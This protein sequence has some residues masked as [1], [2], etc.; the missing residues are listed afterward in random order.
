MGGFYRCGGGGIHASIFPRNMKKRKLVLTG[1]TNV[2]TDG[3]FIHFCKQIFCP[4]SCS[5]LVRPEFSAGPL[6][7]SPFQKRVVLVK[8][9]TSMPTERGKEGKRGFYITFRDEYKSEFAAARPQRM[10]LSQPSKLMI[11]MDVYNSSY[12]GE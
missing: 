3:W 10:N 1:D 4:P 2:T 7:A 12:P 6:S 8:S 5:R 9:S 11:M